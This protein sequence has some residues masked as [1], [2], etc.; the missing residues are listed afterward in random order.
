MS[1]PQPNQSGSR[2]VSLIDL[3][4]L[5]AGV[6]GCSGAV[7]AGKNTGHY[8]I[9]WVIGLA[10]GFGSCF[11]VWTLGRWAIYRLKLHEPALPLPRLLLSW[12]LLFAVVAWVVGCAFIAFWATR[13]ITQ[14]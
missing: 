1:T 11:A 6:A 5:F 13:F 7:L 8:A 12:I 10:V 3:L 2:G 9:G 14:F 4:S